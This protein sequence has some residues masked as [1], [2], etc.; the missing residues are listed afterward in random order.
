MNTAKRPNIVMMV[1]D[2]EAYYRHG[3]DGGTRPA[4]PQLDRL[5]RDGVSFDRAYT[6][7]PLC[8]PA[9]RSMMTG[10]LPHNHGHLTL[11]NR[12]NG[13]VRE[14]GNL[15]TELYKA[16]YDV[17]EYGKWH[18]GP[19]TAKDFGATGLSYPHFGNPYQTPEYTEYCRTLGI[20]EA[21]FDLEHVFLEPVSPDKPVPGP[22]YRCTAPHFHPHVTGVMETETAGHESFFLA[23]LARRRLN[24]LAERRGAEAERPF[25]L[26]LDFYGPHA[27]YLVS[28]EFLDLYPA[29][30]IQEYGSYRDDLSDKPAVYMK[31]WNTPFGT[32]KRL[33][34]P[35]ALDWSE[36]QRILR[37]VYAHVTQVDAAGGIV[38]DA[39]E[40]FGFV[41]DTLVIWTTDHGDPISAHGGHFGKES[42]LS[43]ESIRIPLAM[44][45][46]GYV[47]PNQASPA[48]VSNMDVPVTVL[49][50]AGT[51]F[52]GPVDGRSLFDAVDTDGI[53]DRRNDGTP[54]R[55]DIVVET[56]GHH[57]EKVVG[58]AIV[59]DRY[60]FAKYRFRETPDFVRPGDNVEDMVELYDLESDPYQLTNLARNDSFRDEVHDSIERLDRRRADSHDIYPI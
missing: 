53:D 16:G 55:S 24:G 44:R 18:A 32:D 7:C 21:R 51:S 35:S 43:E 56:H 34:V 40:E 58:R 57:W 38:L 14:Y 22:G 50:A 27:P 46:P 60:H 41:E 26:R 47:A 10:L 30:D 1:N 15:Y 25:F 8:T 17:I 2:H 52:L 49:T 29:E 45:W 11:D 9:R 31:E 3:W 5:Q 28:K 19:G 42:F 13:P 36:W 4:R 33:A 48:L 23:N 39:L 20:E 59:T 12:E 37:Y 54:W 6:T